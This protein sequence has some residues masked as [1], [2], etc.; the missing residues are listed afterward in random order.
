MGGR[1]GTQ[2]ERACQEGADVG[3]K[4]AC[5]HAQ[6]KE[7]KVSSRASADA[8]DREDLRSSQTDI[9]IFDVIHACTAFLVPMRKSGKPAVIRRSTR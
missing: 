8:E 7:Q 5:G 4:Q 6:Q 1:F 3:G 2:S 9:D